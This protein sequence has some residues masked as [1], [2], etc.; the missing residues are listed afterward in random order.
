MGREPRAMVVEDEVSLNE[1]HCRILTNS[2]INVVA[3]AYDGAEAITVFNENDPEKLPNLVLL[4]LMLPKVDGLEVLKVI[5][6]THPDIMVLMVSA[7]S[8]KRDEAKELGADGY[9]L[10]P[11]TIAS[12]VKLIK[13]IFEE[14]MYK[15][16]F[17]DL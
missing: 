10:K 16:E 7:L 12:L 15:G 5:K 3:K 13:E 11:V 4:D 2:G 6:K 9:I 14:D 1:I 8:D 17:I